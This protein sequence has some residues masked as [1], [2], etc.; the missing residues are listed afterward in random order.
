MKPELTQAHLKELLHY[1]PE[2]GHFTWL[3]S[4][5]PTRTGSRAGSLHS[6]GYICIQVDR[7]IYKAHR[8][9]FLY[10]KNQ[11]PTEVDHINRIKSDNRW[12]NLR[13]AT[14]QENM[15]NQGIRVNNTSGYNGVSWHKLTSKWMAYGARKGRLVHLGLFDSLEEAAVVAQAWREEIYGVFAAA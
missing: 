1:D 7:K 15:G 10:M 11:I 3:G 6:R 5:G 12:V 2:T 9:A 8:L 14:H 13:P 4:R